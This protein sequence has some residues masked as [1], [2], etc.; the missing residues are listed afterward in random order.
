MPTSGGTASA[1]RAAAKGR[2]STHTLGVRTIYVPWPSFRAP[3]DFLDS[4]RELPAIPRQDWISAGGRFGGAEVQTANPANLGLHPDGGGAPRSRPPHGI[5]GRKDPF[6]LGG[7]R[8]PADRNDGRDGDGLSIQSLAIR[9][10]RSRPF[11][12]LHPRRDVP[13]PVQHTPDVDVI[14]MLDVEDEVGIPSQRPGPQAR[15]V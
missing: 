15:Q 5:F 11:R 7:L 4:G 10:P 9:R 2:N 6:C 12:F 13:L 8:F 14:G 1:D 3:A